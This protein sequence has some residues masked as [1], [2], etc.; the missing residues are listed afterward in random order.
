MNTEISTQLHVY[1]TFSSEQLQNQST[2]IEELK[3]AEIP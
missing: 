2:D 3:L 1:N